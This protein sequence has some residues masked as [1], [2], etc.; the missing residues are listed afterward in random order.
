MADGITDLSEDVAELI[1]INKQN[2][3]DK[4]NSIWSCDDE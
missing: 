4:I 3:P 1:E 2:I